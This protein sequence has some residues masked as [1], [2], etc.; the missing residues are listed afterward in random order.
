MFLHDVVRD[1]CDRYKQVCDSGVSIQERMKYLGILDNAIGNLVC[2]SNRI[3]D[4]ILAR[5]AKEKKK[6][7]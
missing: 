5:A 3:S 7:P 1:A 2:E 6:I 4:F